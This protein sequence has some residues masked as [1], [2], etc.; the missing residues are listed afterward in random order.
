YGRIVCV[1]SLGVFIESNQSKVLQAQGDMK[2]PM[3]AQVTG[4]LTNIVLDP[5]LIFGWGF[6]PKM[7]I[8][9][10]AIATVIG[11]FVSA[12]IV[13]AKSLCKPPRFSEMSSLIRDIY[14]LGAPSI[15]MQALYTT[16]IA[17]LNLVL[18]GFSDAAVTVLGLYYK[19]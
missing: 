8:A 7:D 10:A 16:Y 12:A 6:I 11:Q 1:G 19:W 2:T 17:G 13:S 14:K 15:V 9:G 3:I 5:I 4:A 18:V